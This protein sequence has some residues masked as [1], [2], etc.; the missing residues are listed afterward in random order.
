MGCS[1][2]FRAVVSSP[3]VCDVSLSYDCDINFDHLVRV[4]SARFLHCEVTVINK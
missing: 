1:I 2:C 4:V 3:E